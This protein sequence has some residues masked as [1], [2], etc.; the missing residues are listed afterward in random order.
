MA[1][2]QGKKGQLIS[3]EAI[4]SFAIFLTGLM[5][6]AFAW[7][8]VSQAYYTDQAERQ[9]QFALIAVSDAA[10][11]SPGDPSG[12][13][14]SAAPQNASSF[15]FAQSRNVLSPTKLAALQSLN[16]S[17]YDTVRERMGAG[18]FELYI[19]VESQDGT[20]QY[21]FGNPAA[22]GS[23][24]VSA[25]SAERLALLNNQAVTLK[26]QVWRTKGRLA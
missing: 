25:V 26:V 1:S 19:S 4:L 7:N 20:V 15:G 11:L 13:E 6:F 3:T 21:A 5:V 16:A 2:I 17:N 14:V 12:W 18:R 10:V 24:T 9:M 23:A 22:A 8:F